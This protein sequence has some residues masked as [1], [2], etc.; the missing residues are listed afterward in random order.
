MPL[1]KLVVVL[2]AAVGAVAAA[3]VHSPDERR[4]D[5][6]EP[7]FADF[8][9]A[10]G[11]IETIDSGLTSR[12]DGLDRAAWKARF[13]RSLQ[14]LN[15]ALA[16]VSPDGMSAPGRRALAGMRSGITF[17]TGA[18]LAPAGLCADAARPSA[19]GRELRTA[20]YA[21]FSSAGDAIQFEGHSYT[22]GDALG[23]LEQLAEPERRRALF[24][25]MEPLWRAVDTDNTPDSP[26]RRLIV[27]EAEHARANIAAAE[28]SLGLPAGAGE[29]WLEQ[30]LE[31]WGGADQGVTLEPWDFRYAHSSGS[32]AVQACAHHLQE[33]N[34]RFFDDLGAN[35][36]HLRVIEDLEMRPG[37]APVD[38]TD[39]AR[40]GRRV[41]GG[42]R[43]AIPRVSVFLREESLSSAGELT[44][45]NG[46]AVHYAAIRARPSLQVPD[47]SSL[48]DESFADITGWSVFNPAWQRKYLGCAST[49][50]DGRRA[51][52][53]A[54]ILDVAWGLFEIRMARDPASDPNA[55]WTD[56]TSRYLHIAPHPEWSWWAI[57]G[58]LVDDPGYMITYALGAFLTA[59][60]RAR[61]RVQIG[62]FDAGNKA[63][64]P[65]VSARLFRYG[66]EV[67]PQELL[68]RF[69]GR[70]VSQTALLAD[71][72][73]IRQP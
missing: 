1:R 50:A 6:A 29:R 41:A 39:I 42:W 13:E 33:A 3:A 68:R 47:D 23:L 65:F 51:R 44:H 38:Y 8:L 55:V 5:A 4:I 34:V 16:A 24:M 9:D 7:V 45:E 22:R 10:A 11:A 64:Y 12:F 36:A 25:A 49:A 43:P 60:L 54:V 63:W 28:E 14:I 72:R 17:R 59:D 32:R 58:Q 30:A 37:K 56:I 57:R 18:S 61:I 70:P 15:A 26:Y 67:E 46:H 73:S 48:A 31:A 71:I 52:L 21:C 27:A 66:G 69:F 19:T 53:G 35:L 40:I 2:L 20:L 62:E